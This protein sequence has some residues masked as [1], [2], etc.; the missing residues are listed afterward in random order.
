M[1]ALAHQPISFF[2]E[3]FRIDDHAVA[4]DAGLALMHDAGR[5]QMKYERVVADLNRVTG[6]MAALIADHD[7]EPLGEQIDDLAF[8]FIA[9]LGSDDSDNH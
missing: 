3:G 7:V 1:N 2:K 6:V 9:P 8:S 4:E 5:K